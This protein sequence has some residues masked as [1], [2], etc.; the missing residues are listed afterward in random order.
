MQKGARQGRAPVADEQPESP[1]PGRLVQQSDPQGMWELRERVASLQAFNRSVSHDLRGP[2]S[3][4]VALARLAA[5]ALHDGNTALA[6]RMVSFISTQGDACARLI[7][8]LFQLA[9]FDHTELHRTDVDL[10]AI[11]RNI[12]DQIAMAQPGLPLPTVDI[13]PMPAVQADPGLLHAVMQN[14]M[15]NA[16]KF[17]RGCEQARV[18]VGCR[19]EGVE[20]IVH[21]R[22]NGIG[23]CAASSEQLFLPFVRLHSSQYEGHGIGLSIVRAAV[24]RHGGRVWA[25]S[26]PG[27]GACFEYSLPHLPVAQ[28][29]TA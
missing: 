16:V 21:V 18:E 14:L 9:K 28:R 25:S 4:I 24:H 23:F 8:A 11:A 20:I 12:L 15:G 26:T 3:S 6:S 2:L 22:D 10:Q 1:K 19:V 5:D 29:E 17:T 27:Q 7:E 13:L